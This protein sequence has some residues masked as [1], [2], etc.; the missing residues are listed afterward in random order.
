MNVKLLELLWSFKIALHMACFL[1]V[2]CLSYSSILNMAAVCFFK[3]LVDIYQTTRCYVLEIEYF[4][5]ELAVSSC[6]LQLSGH[7]QKLFSAWH[8]SKCDI[9]YYSFTKF[10]SVVCAWTGIIVPYCFFLDQCTEC[11]NIRLFSEFSAALDILLTLPL[12]PA[13]WS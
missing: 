3:T 10:C 11:Y 2:S 13:L 1:L 8:N 5:Y 9:I 6:F 7:V 4:I 12:T